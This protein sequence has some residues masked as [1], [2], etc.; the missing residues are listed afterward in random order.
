MIVVF[1]QAV[2]VTMLQTVIKIVQV[3]V[4]VVM[5]LVHIDD[6]GICSGGNSGHVANSGPDYAGECF[7]LWL[8]IVVFVQAVQVTMLQAVINCA[9][10][11]FGVADLDDCGICSGGN[12]GHVANSVKLCW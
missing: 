8:M 7:G 5:D 11:C 1:V 4:L 10:E 3:H 6:C 2:Q 12:S 9:G